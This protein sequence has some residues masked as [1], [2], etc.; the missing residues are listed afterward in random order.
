MSG[1]CN[2]G[3]NDHGQRSKHEACC[4]RI[5]TLVLFASP[6]LAQS[7]TPEEQRACSRDVKRYC[8]H[9]IPQ[10]DFSVCKKIG[11]KS[12]RPAKRFCVITGSDAGAG[13]MTA[14]MVMGPG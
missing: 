5:I 10:G 12:L 11:R 13:D 1:R 9:L 3:G 14:A 2:S 6:M 7:G 8:R 4:F